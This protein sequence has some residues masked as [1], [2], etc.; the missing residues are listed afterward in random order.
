MQTSKFKSWYTTIFILAF[1]GMLLI[2]LR[3][4]VLDPYAIEEGFYLRSRLISLTTNL[5]LTIGDR[6][7]PKVLVGE[8]GWL[9]Y[10]AEG[11]LDAYQRSES[12]TDEQVSQFQANLAALTSNYAERGIT[13]LVLVVPS[14]NSM[15][16]E[17]VPEAITQ[18]GSESKLDQVVSH[19]KAHGTTQIIDL[20]PA[21]TEVKSKHTMYYATDTHWNDYGAYLTYS[22]LLNQLKEK[23]PNLSPR[24]LSDFHEKIREPDVL[25]LANIIGATSLLE[26]KIQLA[27]AFD[28]ATSYK[29]INLGGRKLM[30]SYNPDESLPDLVIYYDSYFFNVNPMLGEH[31]H[32]GVFVQNYSG[33]GLWNLSWVDEQEPDVVIIEFAERY[34]DDLL[35]F[36]DPNR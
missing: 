14:K 16:P 34:I 36:V 30:F 23:Y 11:D 21:L 28:L 32:R 8:G 22:I 17:R 19:L 4:L 2:P 3:T 24:S 18:F 5:R 35:K 26:S 10:T 7:F 9:V 20:R 12:F 6:V 29:S 31:F 15:Y 13:L 27:P 25:D 33:G 1:L